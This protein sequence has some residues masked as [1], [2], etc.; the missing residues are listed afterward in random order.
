MPTDPRNPSRPKP[1]PV[2]I[3]T[4]TIDQ[5]RPTLLPKKLIRAQEMLAKIKPPS[6]Q[7]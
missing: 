7:A 5:Q 3:V 4:N 6:D 2:V 1:N